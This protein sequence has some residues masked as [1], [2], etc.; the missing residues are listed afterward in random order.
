MIGIDIEYFNHENITMISIFQISSLTDDYIVDCL[1]VNLKA[2]KKYIQPLLY[3]QNIIKIM[4]G[5]DNDLI[6]VKSLF[7][8]SLI[9]FI[10]T[11]R[12]DIEL[13][14]NKFDLRGLATLTQQYMGIAMSKEYQVSEWRIRPIPK[15]MLQYAKK[16]SAILPFLLV[17]MMDK[18]SNDTERIRQ[19]IV[20][21]CKQVRKNKKATQPLISGVRTL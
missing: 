6:L 20:G 3:N 14:E 9:N 2:M 12:L 7:N 5:S 10:D 19:M 13:R 1:S 4:H 17:K 11:S 8:L 21:G 16:D 18:I 15:A